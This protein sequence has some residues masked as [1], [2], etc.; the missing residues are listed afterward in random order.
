MMNEKLPYYMVYPMPHVFDEEHM[1]RRDY[2]YM[3]SMY[4]ELVKR[5]IPYIEYECDKMD[6]KYSMLYDEYPD[7]LQIMMMQRR[8]LKQVMEKELLADEMLLQHLIT[9]LLWQEIYQ[10]R[11]VE[12]RT[13]RKFY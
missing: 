8:I 13:Q 1:E 4:P 9:V 6:Y 2:E 5:I 7:K 12:R 3:R 10:R 11:T